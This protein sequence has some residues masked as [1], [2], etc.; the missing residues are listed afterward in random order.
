M[1][2]RAMAV[3]AAIPELAGKLQPSPNQRQ[4]Q[5]P[6]LNIAD[7]AS[8]TD[9]EKCRILLAAE[10]ALHDAN[11]PAYIQLGSMTQFVNPGTQK[12][13]FASW[14]C[15]R[16]GEPNSGGSGDKKVNDLVTKFQAEREQHV[17]NAAVAV[18]NQDMATATSELAKAAE[19][20]AII[21]TL[22]GESTPSASTSTKAEN[23]PSG[24][25]GDDDIPF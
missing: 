11:I 20:L 2:T 8:Y 7:L 14:P 18:Q 19:K 4:G 24:A 25:N 6:Q 21:N 3:L 17:A 22:K 12:R 15:I 5:D 1:I 16:L 9:A 10:K 23:G 13:V